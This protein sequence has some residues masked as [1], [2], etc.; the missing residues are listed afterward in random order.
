LQRCRSCLIPDTRPDTHFFD[1]ECAACRNYRNRPAIDWEAR[2]ADLVRILET[3]P[4]NGSGF[5]CIVPSSGGKDSH[6]QVL[7]LIELGARPLVVTASTCMLTGI[8]RANIDNLARYATTIEVTP[9]RTV[10]A[11][12]NRL[13]L[14]LVGDISWPEHV[15][16]FTTPFRVAADLGIPT[17]FY[18]ECP[19]REY[20]GP[21]G[22][23]DALQLTAR[24][25]AEFGGF[26]GLRPS[27]LVG[28]LGITDADMADYVLPPPER[29]AGISAWF[30]GQFIPWDSWRNADIAKAAGMRTRLPSVGNW[31]DF[32]NL[33]NAM[34][35]VHDYFGFLKYGFGRMAAQLSVDIRAG[36]LTREDAKG[37]VRD[38]G[39]FPDAYMGVPLGKV[40]KHI[41]M[42]EPEF[43]AVCD[44]FTNWAIFCRV[45]DDAGAR[46]VLLA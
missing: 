3:A 2:R 41:G 20:S 6:Y 27:D 18:G 34:T 11:K 13:G 5:D 10:R 31:W 15:S 22:S 40:L 23:E 25:R 14:E 45:V 19:Q 44:R 38:D 36:R 29:L 12:L 24:W 17:L 46:P 37:H 4:K 32:E 26:L 9:N 42:T 35:G 21:P 7:T 8:G 1:G 16:I 39:A 30:L 28:Q 43:R 33:D